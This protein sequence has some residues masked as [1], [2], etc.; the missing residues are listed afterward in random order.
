MK[1]YSDIQQVDACNDVEAE[2]EK[3]ESILDVLAPL[4]AILGLRT[5]LI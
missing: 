2:A 5:A 4:V 3:I 1:T